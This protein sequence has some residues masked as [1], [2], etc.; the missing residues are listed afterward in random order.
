MTTRRLMLRSTDRV[1]TAP[2]HHIRTGYFLR[3]VHELPKVRRAVA[4]PNPPVRQGTPMKE[5]LDVEG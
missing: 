1:A 3:P 5:S 4:R 2:W